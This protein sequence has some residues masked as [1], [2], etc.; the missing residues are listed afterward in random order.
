MT[1]FINTKKQGYSPEQCGK[2]LTVGELIDLLNGFDPD[3]KIFLKN[4]NG[5]TFGSIRD[6]DLDEEEDENEE[7]EE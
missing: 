5:Y 7:E 2:T 1:I 4:D 3:S 6:S